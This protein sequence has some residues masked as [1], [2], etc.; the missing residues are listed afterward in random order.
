M[1][2]KIYLNSFFSASIAI[3]APLFIWGN[4]LS[5]IPWIFQKLEMNNSTLGYLFMI[6]SLVQLFFSQL[7]GR[8]II[9]NLGSRIS[10]VIGLVVFS[11][12]PIF[13][14]F[15]NSITFFL[16]ASVPAGI[17]FGI[18]NTTATAVTSVAENKTN[19]ILQTY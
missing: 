1:D 18:I 13:F 12:T 5:H 8:L 14:V 4:T 3:F 2:K 9:P 15:S 11:S 7:S 6:F 16:F 17:G 19:K 10:L